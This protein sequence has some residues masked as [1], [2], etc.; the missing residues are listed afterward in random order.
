M[1]KIVDKEYFS[2]NVVKFEV[3][4]PLIA[5]SRKAGH[6]VIVRV[7]EKGERIPLTIAASD[8]AKGTITIVIQAVGASSK[9]ICD[10]NTG[11]YI[12]DVVGPLGQATHIE[13][14]GTVICAGGGVGIAPMLPIIEAMKKAGNKVI[15]VLAARTKDLVILEKQVAEYSD[16]VIVMTDDGSYGYKGLIT[17]GI[18]MVVNRE[19][20]DL[21]VTIGP[22]IMMKF[23]SL[24]TQKYN[25]PTM[26]S[27][28]TI[29]VDGTGM[30]GA[31]RITVG[32]KTKFVCVDGPEFNAHEVDFDEMLMRLKAYN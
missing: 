7:G 21:C 25:I 9:K 16:E 26:A 27:L 17:N 12:T 1:N 15:S 19:K 28:N 23:V 18:E 2:E 6:F 11:D 4:A 13:N 31:C 8:V 3:E 30:C 24:L 20:V 22:A 29:M 10:L 32:G 5:R 14:Y